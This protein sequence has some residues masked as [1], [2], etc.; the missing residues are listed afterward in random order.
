MLSV[1]VKKPYQFRFTNGTYRDIT[2]CGHLVYVY[3]HYSGWRLKQVV[4]LGLCVRVCE[5]GGVGHT[6]SR[7]S[8]YILYV[9][10]HVSVH[11]VIVLFKLYCKSNWLREL[12]PGVIDVKLKILVFLFCVSSTDLCH[13]NMLKLKCYITSRV[14]HI[15]SIFQCISFLLSIRPYRYNSCCLLI[16]NSNMF[17]SPTKYLWINEI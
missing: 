12:G 7:V 10:G 9:I 17:L 2:L 5:R 13:L 1:F 11:S 14:L 3:T 16:F 15:L 6:G 8:Y 4:A